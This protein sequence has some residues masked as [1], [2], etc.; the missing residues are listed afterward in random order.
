MVYGTGLAEPAAP[1]KDREIRGKPAK[2]GGIEYA[3]AFGACG[4]RVG[5]LPSLSQ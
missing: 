1:Q 3:I 2:A 4:D 5:H